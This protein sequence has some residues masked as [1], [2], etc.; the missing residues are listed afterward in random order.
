[1]GAPVA[2]STANVIFTC[3]AK[4]AASFAVLGA[5]SDGIFRGA[6]EAFTQVAAGEELDWSEIGTATAVGASEGFKWGAII[7]AVAGGIK[8]AGA[9]KATQGNVG[10]YKELTALNSTVNVNGVKTQNHHVIPDAATDLAKNEGLCIRLPEDFHRALTSTGNSK[11]AMGFR[12]EMRKLL[13]A[14]KLKEAYT[15]G[16]DDIINTVNQP[17]FAHYKADILADIVNFKAL[18]GLF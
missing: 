16:L 13:D 9:I 11:T 14:G 5:A 8:G 3:A 18:T 10:T 6:S 12:N 2:V 1:V 7:G 15:M 4:S 17:Q